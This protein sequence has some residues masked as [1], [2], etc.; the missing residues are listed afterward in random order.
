MIE[1]QKLTPEQRRQIADE[2]GL[3]DM[4]ATW[5]AEEALKQA[6][7]NYERTGNLLTSAQVQFDQLEAAER[8]RFE[9]RLAKMRQPLD[10]AEQEHA[11]STMELR[12]AENTLSAV[13][14]TYAHKV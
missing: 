6:K 14:D 13:A 2:I 1:L 3:T 5:K 8:I 10:A 4:L 12:E 9:A 7:K 11:E